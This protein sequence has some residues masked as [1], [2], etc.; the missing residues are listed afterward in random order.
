M[1]ALALAYSVLDAAYQ[2]I[3]RPE[4]AAFGRRTVEIFRELG[5]T[6]KAAMEEMNIAVQDYAEGRWDEAVEGY[7]RVYAE[8]ARIGD[9]AHASYAQMNLGEV[10][11]SRGALDEAEAVLLEAR[12][13]LRGL[14]MRAA[15]VFAE[16]QLGRLA[17]AR[18][19]V[20]DAVSALSALRDEAGSIEY[21]FL[22]VESSVH[23]ASAL[24]LSGRPAEALSVLGDAE[25]VAGDEA[26][27]LAVP[28]G[29]VRA[30]ALVGLGRSTEA[31]ATINTS[32]D[33]RTGAGPPVRGGPAPSSS[34]SDPK[35]E[36]SVCD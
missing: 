36:R 18:G 11:I 29:R 6:R 7:T 5:D 25:R 8:L 9:T 28:I 14:Q 35:R 3:G 22:V 21:A 34:C 31:A 19:R 16:I 4:K 23:L 33:S 10:L 15:A 26:M 24:V 13:A 12:R 30:E 20:D 32:L 1:R 17:I 2:Q 27:Q